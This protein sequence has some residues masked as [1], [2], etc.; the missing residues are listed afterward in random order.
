[1]ENHWV[2][3]FQITMA[4][5]YTYSCIVLSY[6]KYIERNCFSSQCYCF[7][8]LCIVFLSNVTS[9]TVSFLQVECFLEFISLNFLSC[10][11]PRANILQRL[12]CFW[13]SKRQLKKPKLSLISYHLYGMIITFW[14]LMKKTENAYGVIQVSKE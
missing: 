4:H 5:L 8:C 13:I 9:R 10:G 6:C 7:I 1:M 14:G 2:I 12:I 3:Q 11:I